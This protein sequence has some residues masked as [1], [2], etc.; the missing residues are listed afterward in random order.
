MHSF[1]LICLNYIKERWKD[2][3]EDMAN[4]DKQLRLENNAMLQKNNS[5]LNKQS[6]SKEDMLLK[7]EVPGQNSD[8]K[9]V[10]NSENTEQIKIHPDTKLILEK[11][12]VNVNFDK[13]LTILYDYDKKKKEIINKLIKKFQETKD[14]K[15]A[16]FYHEY[17]IN[18]EMYLK[19]L[20]KRIKQSDDINTVKGLIDEI[21][22]WFAYKNIKGIKFEI[23]IWQT[24]ENYEGASIDLKENRVVSINQPKR[25]NKLTAWFPDYNIDRRIYTKTKKIFVNNYETNKIL[26]ICL[27]K[28]LIEYQQLHTKKLEMIK[29]NVETIGNKNK[30]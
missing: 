9:K 23:I 11:Y 7:N 12:F 25:T 18:S 19:K 20:L 17:N 30:S 26:M 16:D 14:K 24:N 8:E 13:L 6:E 27:T 3:D 4:I 10:L 1:I 29:V 28:S 21:A 22:Y 5:N 15:Y 2:S